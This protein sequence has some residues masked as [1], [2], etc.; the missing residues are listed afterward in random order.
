MGASS[1]DAFDEFLQLQLLRPHAIDRRENAVEDVVETGVGRLLER[2][3]VKRV[4]D[5]ENGVMIS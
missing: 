5:D 4:F 3:D 1:K 2:N